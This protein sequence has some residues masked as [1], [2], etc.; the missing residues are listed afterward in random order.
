MDT[1]AQIIPKPVEGTRTVIAPATMPAIK[2]KG[3]TNYLCGNCN[4]KIV[5]KVNKGQ[6]SDIVILCSVCGNYNE[7]A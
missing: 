2:G 3:D 5:E 4:T 7:I 1:K 6:T